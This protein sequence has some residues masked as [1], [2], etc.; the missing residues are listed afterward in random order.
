M[1]LGAALLRSAS[2]TAKDG[3]SGAESAAKEIGIK[4]RIND[5][6]PRDRKPSG[7]SL[8]ENKHR[9]DT[10]GGELHRTCV[11]AL[12]AYREAVVVSPEEEC[13]SLDGFGSSMNFPTAER[14]QSIAYKSP[15]PTG[16]MMRTGIHLV[17]QGTNKINGT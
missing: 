10:N 16:M 6:F 4:A 15:M 13:P 12:S 8:S 9:T 17:V 1:F 5:P 2:R 3:E 7:P 11:P 14:T